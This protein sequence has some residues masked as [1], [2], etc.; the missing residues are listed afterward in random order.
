[1]TIFGND[2]KLQ[3]AIVRMT[4]LKVILTNT[5]NTKNN[6]RVYSHFAY[7]DFDE[8]NLECEDK[9][10]DNWKFNSEN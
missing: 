1:M 5:T 6:A 4:F 9:L 2:G 8:I 10:G 7:I 3:G